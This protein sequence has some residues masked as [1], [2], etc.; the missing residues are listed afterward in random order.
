M[1]RTDRRSDCPINFGLQTFGDSWSLLIIRDLIF[2]GPRSYTD[3][4]DGPE[5][6]ST[7]VLATRLRTLCSNG[8]VR[9]EG[10]GKSTKYFLTRA[11]VDLLPI[12]LEVMLWSAEHDSDLT[13]PKRFMQRL[14][15]DREGVRREVEAKAAEAHGLR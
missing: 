11:G 6:I 8:I 9:R 7:S 4:V 15:A 3:F 13:T 10:A 5:G 1:K 14:Q 12:I 2:G